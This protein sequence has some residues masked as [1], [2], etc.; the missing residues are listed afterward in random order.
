VSSSEPRSKHRRGWIPSTVR[1]CGVHE[2]D[3]DG[4]QICPCPRTE[5]SFEAEGFALFDFSDLAT[6]GGSDAEAIDGFHA[7]EAAH[8][9]MLLHT[10]QSSVV[11]RV[12]TADADT[13]RQRLTASGPYEVF[14]EHEF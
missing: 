9:R 8:V 4:R 2:N 10:Q 11:V 5:A 14:G 6:T 1:P 3:G 13:L 7:S 12:H